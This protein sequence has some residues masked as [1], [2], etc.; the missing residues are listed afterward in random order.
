MGNG[1]G[2]GNPTLA[3]EGDPVDLIDDS[4]LLRI[5]NNLMFYILRINTISLVVLGLLTL[6]ITW[7]LT[8]LYSIGF[9][10]LVDLF[11]LLQMLKHS[12]KFRYLL[13]VRLILKSMIEIIHKGR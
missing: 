5:I 3:D 12:T 11:E 10:W 9:L 1:I 7:D 6:T 2:E 8:Y 13:H 4:V